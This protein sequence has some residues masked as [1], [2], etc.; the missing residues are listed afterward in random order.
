MK[1]MVLKEFCE[2]EIARDQRHQSDLPLK[3]E[4]LYMVEMPAPLPG[5]NQILVRVFA[6]GI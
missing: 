1:A 4:P 2:I 5:P 3:K 6:C